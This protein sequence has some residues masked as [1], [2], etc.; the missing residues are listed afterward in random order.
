VAGAVQVLVGADA[1]R[2]AARFLVTAQQFGAALSGVTSAAAALADQRSW[3]GATA[4]RFRDDKAAIAVHV[5]VLAASVLRM[6]TGA[7]AVIEAIDRDDMLGAAALELGG[8]T[9]NAPGSGPPQVT[10]NSLA[11]LADLTGRGTDAQ[12]DAAIENDL[13][14]IALGTLMMILGAGGEV[15]GIG[16]DLTGVGIPAGVATDIISAGVIAA[17]ATTFAHG[18]TDLG[19]NIAAMTSSSSGG[20]ARGGSGGPGGPKKPRKAR[21]VNNLERPPQDGDRG[22]QVRDPTTGKVITDIDHVDG[23]ALREEK[24][25]VTGTETGR[26]TPA[27]WVHDDLL[28]Q[29]DRYIKARKFLK[30]YE[31]APLGVDFTRPGV[32]PELK[33]AVEDGIREWQARNPG[34]PVDVRWPPAP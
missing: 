7:V 28:P 33:Q 23:P 5:R 25:L 2:L 27:E 19:A 9:T 18:A 32:T 4:E 17:G 8:V 14:Q 3:N 31:N 24:G 34:V 13:G 16:M 21:V 6:A 20:Y 1:A 26:A 30:G 12:R 22:Y 11:L 15:A 29:L 10:T